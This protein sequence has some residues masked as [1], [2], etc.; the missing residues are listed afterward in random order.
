MGLIEGIEKQGNPKVFG[1]QFH[2]EVPTA[3]GSDEFLPIFQYLVK[4]AKEKK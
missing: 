1:V 3:N 2:P 4:L